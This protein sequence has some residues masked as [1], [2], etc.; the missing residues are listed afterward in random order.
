MFKVR[1]LSAVTREIRNLANAENIV[2]DEL[3]VIADD[4][5]RDALQRVPVDKGDL[6]A[7]AYVSQQG[8]DWVV[9]FSAKY[10]PYQEFGT[11]QYTEVPI[12][13]EDFAME[14]FVSGKGHVHAQPF[15]LPAFF[16]E[17]DKAVERLENEIRKHFNLVA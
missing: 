6:K 2:R 15:L 5:L 3:K 11:G 7:S 16:E 10:A 14:F 9:G 1:G 4:I 17:R 8:K 12:G 13:F